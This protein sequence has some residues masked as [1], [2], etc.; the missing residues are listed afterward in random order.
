MVVV[1]M[2]MVVGGAGY[3][4]GFVGS[5][6]DETGRSFLKCRREKEFLCGRLAKNEKALKLKW[7]KKNSGKI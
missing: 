1:V 5:G 2:A 7:G 4:C 3:G 6:R